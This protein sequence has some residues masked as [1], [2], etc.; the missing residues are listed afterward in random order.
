[1]ISAE[2]AADVERPLVVGAAIFVVASAGVAI[3]QAIAP[4]SRGWWL[5]AFFALVGGVSQWL[6]GAGLVAAGDAGT[7][8]RAP[9]TPVLWNGG[10]LLVAASDL[11][12]LPVGVLIGSALL[13]TALLLFGCR[14]RA[15]VIHERVTPLS[16]GYAALLVVL[17]ASVLIG[18]GLAAALPGQ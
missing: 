15:I 16:V 5:V 2:A 18:A 6:L 11:A 4:M 17:A 10:T 3:F 9:G 7:S 1:M 8:A 14:L 13:L 12:D